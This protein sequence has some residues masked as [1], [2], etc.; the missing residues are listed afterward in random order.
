MTNALMLVLAGMTACSV[1][2]LLGLSRLSRRFDAQHEAVMK[3]AAARRAE[4]ATQS[5]ANS[6]EPALERLGAALER[7][8]GDD[9][10][11]TGGA[12]RGQSRLVLKPDDV[13]EASAEADPAKAESARG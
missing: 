8:L 4:P 7:A 3:S 6:Y 2:L 11:A 9:S 10:A 13:V 12:A 1:L 5:T